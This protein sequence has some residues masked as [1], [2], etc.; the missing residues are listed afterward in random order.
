M[1]INHAGEGG[2]YAEMVQDRSFDALAHATGFSSG[3]EDFMVVADTL[4]NITAS[5][6]FEKLPETASRKGQNPN[7]PGPSR[8][9]LLAV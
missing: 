5:D 4:L 3:K 6:F 1:Q 2:L 9:T 7:D 8:Y